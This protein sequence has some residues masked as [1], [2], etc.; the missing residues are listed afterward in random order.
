MNAGYNTMNSKICFRCK[1][2][3]KP[4]SREIWHTKHRFN[5]DHYFCYECNLERA[6]DMVEIFQKDHEVLCKKKYRTMFFRNIVYPI[7]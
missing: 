7:S 5:D 2:A 3:N 4:L 1:K 6:K